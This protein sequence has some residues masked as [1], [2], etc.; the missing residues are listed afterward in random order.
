[1][2]WYG[3]G[4]SEFFSSLFII[5]AEKWFPIKQNWRFLARMT[6]LSRDRLIGVRQT[7]PLRQE[8]S[9]NVSYT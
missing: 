8:K 2:A 7:D 9:M 1:V 3:V 4:E 5:L 6:A